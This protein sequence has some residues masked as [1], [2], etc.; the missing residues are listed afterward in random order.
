MLSSPIWDL[1]VQEVSNLFFG[2][3]PRPEM[4]TIYLTTTIVYDSI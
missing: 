3:D 4:S 2:S 1:F